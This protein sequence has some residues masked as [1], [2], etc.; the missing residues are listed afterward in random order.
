MD[1]VLAALFAAIQVI[2][3]LVKFAQTVAPNAFGSSPSDQAQLT[4]IE[5]TLEQLDS[6]IQQYST[7]ILAALSTLSQEVFGNEMAGILSSADEAGINLAE[8][9]QNQ[10]PTAQAQALST[11]E[12]GLA[13][14]LEEYENNVYPGPSMML[15]LARAILSR[16]AVLQIFS[17]FR[18]TSDNEQIT[19][20]VQFLTTAVNYVSAYITSM[21]QVNVT[22]REVTV[23]GATG[24]PAGHFFTVTVSYS[25][26]EGSVA[27]NKTAIGATLAAA[28]QAAQPDVAQAEQDQKQGLADDL[29]YYQVTNIENII[30]SVNQ[31]LSEA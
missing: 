24:K 23:T 4:E 7:Q 17:T 29:N 18:S 25:N 27:Y 10:S 19:S 16:V 26:L 21:N 20:A 15:V 28:T 31:F 22:N 6:D 9:E 14:I 30:Q 12:S 5:S 2:G 11:S 1:P 8:W 3:N 13:Q